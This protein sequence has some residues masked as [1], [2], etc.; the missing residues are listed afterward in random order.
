MFIQELKEKGIVNQGELNANLV[1]AESSIAIVCKNDSI[2]NLQ[3]FLTTLK[4][5]DSRRK[6]ETAQ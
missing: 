4:D 1:E 3:Y 6:S 2:S 5:I